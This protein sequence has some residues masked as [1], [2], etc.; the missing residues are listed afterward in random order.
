LAGPGYAKDLAT[1]L[2]PR[3]G[4]KRAMLA[5]VLAGAIVTY[6]GISVFVAVFVLFPI[7]RELFRQADIPRRLI[8]ATIGLGIVTF[9]MTAIPGAPQGPT[10]IPG[11]HV[12]IE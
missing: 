12:Q 9:T 4:P 2:T 6:G 5:T 11:P 7:T 8:P 10:I 3:L 1:I